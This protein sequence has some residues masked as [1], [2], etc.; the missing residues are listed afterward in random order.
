MTSSAASTTSG[1]IASASA[2]S[3]SAVEG[4][5]KMMSKPMTFAPAARSRSHELGRAGPRGQGQRWPISAKDGS[6]MATIDTPGSGGGG[7]AMVEKMS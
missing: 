6:S 3:A 1:P 4:S 2:A 7:G 5:A